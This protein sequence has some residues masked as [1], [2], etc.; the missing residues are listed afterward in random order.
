MNPLLHLQV[1]AIPC[2]GTH[3]GEATCSS[4]PR[5]HG[6]L[7]PDVRKRKKTQVIAR[8]LEGEITTLDPAVST[9]ANSSS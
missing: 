5:L 6:R 9:P 1:L 4:G 3:E 7:Q 2:V 8:M